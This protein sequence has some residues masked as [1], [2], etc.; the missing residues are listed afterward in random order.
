MEPHSERLSQ[1]ASSDCFDVAGGDGFL[2][3]TSQSVA[4]VLVSM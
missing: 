4:G 2:T 3:S 1:E